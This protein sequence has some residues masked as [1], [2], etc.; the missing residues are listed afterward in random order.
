MSLVTQ[1]AARRRDSVRATAMRSSQAPF[2][3]RAALAGVI[4]SAC[5]AG[6]LVVAALTLDLELRFFDDGTAVW[7]AAG[8]AAAA[9]IVASGLFALARKRLEFVGPAL[10]SAGISLAWVAFAVVVAGILYVYVS[11]FPN[12]D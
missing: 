10:V 11:A 6:F 12:P 8:P 5:L 9:A 2:S 4:G 1:A 3:A 7:F